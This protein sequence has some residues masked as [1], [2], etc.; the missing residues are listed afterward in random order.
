M[1][2]YILLFLSIIATIQIASAQNKYVSA[3]TLNIRSQPST[4][5]KIVGKLQLGDA[6]TI[7]ATIQDSEWVRIETQTCKSGYVHSDYLVTQLSKQDRAYATTRS[8]Y[9]TSSSSSSSSKL[10]Y[11][12]YRKYRSGPRGGCY[13]INSNGKKTYV[14]RSYCR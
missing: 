10:K 12:T 13:Y 2:N 4:S 9:G 5:A 14:D 11:R 1:K 3:N 8:K 7:T 6:V